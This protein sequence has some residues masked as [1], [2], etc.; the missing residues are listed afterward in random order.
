MQGDIVY[1]NYGEEKDFKLLAAKGVSCQDK[2]VI[3]RYGRIFPGQM[4]IPIVYCL[5]DLTRIVTIIFVN[6]LLVLTYH[7]IYAQVWGHVAYKL[8]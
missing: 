4:V 7:A 3:M 6:R 1:A 8:D 2:I 5:V